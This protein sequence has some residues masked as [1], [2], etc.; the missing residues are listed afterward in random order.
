MP[1]SEKINDYYNILKKYFNKL[2]VLHAEAEAEELEYIRTRTHLEELESKNIFHISH[3]VKP[4]MLIDIYSFLDFY[5][6]RICKSK[7]EFFKFELSVSDIRGKNDLHSYHKYMTRYLGMDLKPFQNSYEHL[8]K[9][10]EVR[11]HFIHGGGHIGDEQKIK[12][13]EK[14]KGIQISGST[15]FVNDTFVW[16]SLEHA[17]NYLVG[18]AKA[19]IPISKT[20]RD[21]VS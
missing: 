12:E 20:I 13:M 17:K 3:L 1:L 18:A 2:F 9:L 16:Q 10:R 6:Q 5:A 15:I 21:I 14:I 8:Q 7:K 4:G 19:G 11:N